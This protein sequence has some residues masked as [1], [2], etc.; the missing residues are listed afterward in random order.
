MNTWKSPRQ[1]YGDRKRALLSALAGGP[2][3]TTELS[4]ALGWPQRLVAAHLTLLQRRGV[5]ARTPF[6]NEGRRQGSRW[7]VAR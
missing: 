1:P 5:V 7:S 6:R 3:T 4:A 2:A